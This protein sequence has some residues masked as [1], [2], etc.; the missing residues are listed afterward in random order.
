MRRVTRKA[1]TPVELLVC[2]WLLSRG[3]DAARV[4][5]SRTVLLA[6]AMVGR[7]PVV[8]LRPRHADKRMYA[9][10][11]GAVEW[12]QARGADVY[13]ATSRPPAPRLRSLAVACSFGVLVLWPCGATVACDFNVPGKPGTGCEAVCGKGWRARVS[14]CNGELFVAYC[15][16]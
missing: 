16:I 12:Y 10:V 2:D 4:G 8:V 13:V 11:T 5:R 7:R 14:R 15:R 3:A 9:R 6:V 1:V